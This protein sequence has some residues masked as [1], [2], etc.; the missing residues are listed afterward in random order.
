[1]AQFPQRLGLD[2]GCLGTVYKND[3]WGQ[4]MSGDSDVWG[5]YI[6][7]S[8]YNYKYDFDVKPAFRYAVPIRTAIFLDITI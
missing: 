1:V 4:M 6:N 8:G 3:V 5:Q 7:N 2:L